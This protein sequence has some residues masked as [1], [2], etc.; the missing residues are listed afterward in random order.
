MKKQPPID[1]DKNHHEM[2][3][4]SWTTKIYTIQIVRFILETGCLEESLYC[5][6]K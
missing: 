6:I 1:E 3:C 5:F 2:G 4:P